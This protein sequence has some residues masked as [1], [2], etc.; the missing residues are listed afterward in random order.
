MGTSHSHDP[1]ESTAM[2][3]TNALTNRM[4]HPLKL[5]IITPSFN[6]V[7]YIE[8]TIRSVLGQDYPYVE[9][10]VIDGGSTD[11]TVDVLKKYP[12]LRWVSEKDRGQADALNKGLAKASGD[13]IGWIN[14]DDYYEPKIFGSIVKC[15]E[16]P[17]VMWVTGHLTF[18]WDQTGELVAKKSPPISY[19]RLLNNPDIVRQPATFFRKSFI[20]QAGGWSSCFFMAMDFDLWV[21]L[22]KISSPQ[23]IDK[24][25]AYFRIHAL[26]KT[27][28]ANT[29]RQKREI[30]TILTRENV[31]W[32]IRARVSM[33]KNWATLKGRVKEILLRLKIISQKGPTRQLRADAGMKG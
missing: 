4:A 19:A 22:A 24:N 6:Q 12:H 2:N 33:Q 5:T 11:C 15:F 8:Q 7:P 16:D 17:D 21:R 1:L 9:H 27:S 32:T 29:L 25:L 20:E 14:S 28:H 26:Q 31:S 18:L 30:L 10:I 23:M 3:S 13:I